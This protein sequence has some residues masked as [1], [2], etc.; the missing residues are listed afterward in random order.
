MR[1]LLN[2]LFT[3]RIVLF[4]NAIY[5]LNI[6]EFNVL[7]YLDRDHQNGINGAFYSS[8]FTGSSPITLIIATMS[9]S[10]LKLSVER[11]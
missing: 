5:S 7:H 9:Y 4:N 1:K 3:V 11:V 6:Y 8:S 2:S 10:V